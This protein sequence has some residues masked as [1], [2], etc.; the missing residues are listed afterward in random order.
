MDHFPKGP[1]PCQVPSETG[2][3][4]VSGTSLVG[5]T[6]NPAVCFSSLFVFGVVEGE[7]CGDLFRV[8]GTPEV[9]GNAYAETAPAVTLNIQ[10]TDVVMFWI[11]YKGQFL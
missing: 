7:G 8:W 6:G 1:G 3:V 11:C 2:R 10:S 9:A 4:S 5:C